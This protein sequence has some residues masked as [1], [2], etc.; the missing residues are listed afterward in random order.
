[1]CAQ[2]EQDLGLGIIQLANSKCPYYW[3]YTINHITSRN[4]PLPV[5]VGIILTN[6]M[7]Q[8]PKMDLG[9]ERKIMPVD[10]E[11][12]HR[13]IFGK[14]RYQHST[15]LHSHICKLLL[16]QSGAIPIDQVT[17]LYYF[18]AIITTVD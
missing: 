2:I 7:P 6:N 15:S 16:V 11:P 14:S 18:L 13:L 9:S 3:E 1:M 8:A 5:R 4:T 17:T 10:D 12:Y